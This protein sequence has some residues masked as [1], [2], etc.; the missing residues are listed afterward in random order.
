MITGDERDF[1]SPIHNSFVATVLHPVFFT[2]GYTRSIELNDWKYRDK[3]EITRAKVIREYL[4]VPPSRGVAQ[5]GQ[6]ALQVGSVL[7]C[8]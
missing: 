7:C 5:W 3:P 4:D 8:L 2:S 1:P 6:P